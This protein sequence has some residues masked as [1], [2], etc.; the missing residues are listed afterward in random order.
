MSLWPTITVDTTRIASQDTETVYKDELNFDFETGESAPLPQPSSHVSSFFGG[1]TPKDFWFHINA[2]LIVYGATE[3]SATV[4]FAG[5]PIALRPD[6]SFRFRFA[7]PDGTYELPAT[8]V[9]ADGTD[10]RA[11]EL[12][13]SRATE[14]RGHVAAA[15]VDP[16]LKAPPGASA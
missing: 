5:K 6:G 14:I 12:K 13:F 2:E 9:S 1:E 16:A 10:G 15:P 8:A 4:T 11:A 3:P 7:L